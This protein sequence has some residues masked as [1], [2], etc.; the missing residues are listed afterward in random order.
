[1]GIVWTIILLFLARVVN[2]HRV[3]LSD[4]D[5]AEDGGKPKEME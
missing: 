4:G 1:M 5:S 3:E 2:S